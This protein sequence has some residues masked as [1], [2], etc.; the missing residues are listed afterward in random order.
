[1]CKCSV[2]RMLEE[3][4]THTNRHRNVEDLERAGRAVCEDTV[5]SY[6]KAKGPIKGFAWG[7]NK[8]AGS[9]RYGGAP[10]MQVRVVPNWIMGA[11]YCPAIF[12]D[13]WD[14]IFWW[15]FV[16]P[17]IQVPQLTER[18]YISAR[19]EVP[20]SHFAPTVLRRAVVLSYFPWTPRFPRLINIQRQVFFKQNCCYHTLS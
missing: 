6:F 15:A 5:P 3:R 19:Q 9:R 11:K 1:M 14:I 13:I 18:R 7:Q 20:R 2:R 10:E 8:I 12:S 17:L 4:K 16:F